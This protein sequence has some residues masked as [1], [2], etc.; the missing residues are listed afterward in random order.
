[1]DIYRDMKEIISQKTHPALSGKVPRNHGSFLLGILT[2]LRSIG[3]YLFVYSYC[4]G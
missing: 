4:G 3:L 2:R 1:M